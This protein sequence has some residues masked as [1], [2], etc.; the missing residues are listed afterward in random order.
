MSY[1]QREYGQYGGNPYGGGYN[2][3]YNTGNPYGGGVSTL[4]TRR[5]YINLLTAVRGSSNL[6]NHKTLDNRL[7]SISRLLTTLKLRN[8]R[9]VSLVLRTTLKRQQQAKVQ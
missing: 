1:D 7:S 2:Q 3:G 5:L 4:N 9:T 8:T 6:N